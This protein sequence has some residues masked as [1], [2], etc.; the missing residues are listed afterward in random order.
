M[1][2]LMCRTLAKPVM[3]GLIRQGAEVKSLWY[4]LYVQ[5]FC[6]VLTARQE[7]VDFV[8]HLLHKSSPPL[9][10]LVGNNGVY[11]GWGC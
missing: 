4:T 7:Q 5:A 3:G 11:R 1:G 10:V 6:Q 2:P 9:P 8:L